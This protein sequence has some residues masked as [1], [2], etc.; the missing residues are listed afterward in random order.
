MR[1]LVTG[2]GGLL[3]LEV[4]DELRARGHEAIAATR[5]GLDITD[6]MGPAQIAAKSFGELDWCINCAAYTAVDRAE[7]EER[8]AMEVN[9]LG[10]GYL[11][12]AAQAV[13]LR[14]LHVSTDFV[15]DGESDRPYTEEDPTNPIG[16]YGRSKLDGER[17]LLGY[18]RG[19]VVRT[20]WLYGPRGSCFPKT[21]LRAYDA[22]KSLR[23]VADQFGTPTYTPH[24]ARVLADIVDKDP[25]PGIYHAAGPDVVSWHE[26][27]RRVISVC[28]GAEPQIEPIKTEDW[29]TPAKRP[30]FSALDSSKLTAAGIGPMPPLDE[31]VRAF[32]QTL[33]AS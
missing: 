4:V 17:R 16:V 28:R 21:M 1:V 20:S 31:G 7:S 26:F 27:A 18:Y 15:F 33:Q 11:M 32:C 9:N 29:P 24:L 13:S 8:E 10:V 5:Q 22:G 6:P 30:R 3:G 14:V 23:V 25:F 19:V 2:A 12:T